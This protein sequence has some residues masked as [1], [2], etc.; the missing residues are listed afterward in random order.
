MKDIL[1]P[2]NH[3]KFIVRNTKNTKKNSYESPICTRTREDVDHFLQQLAALSRKN[4]PTRRLR[5]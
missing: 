4:F 1:F 5:A 3:L 2:R